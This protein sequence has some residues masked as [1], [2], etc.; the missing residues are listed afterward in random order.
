MFM[1]QIQSQ[2]FIVVMV[3]AA[4][5]LQFEVIS[6]FETEVFP[7]T[8]DHYSSLLFLPHGVKILLAFMFGFVALP[9]IFIGRFLAGILLLDSPVYDALVGTVFGCIAIFT[10]VAFINVAFKK[11]WYAGINF[12]ENYT[13]NTFHIFIILVLLSTFLNVV[14][15]SAYYHVEATIMMPFRYFVGDILG[16]V[17]IFTLLM[18]AR[19]YIFQYFLRKAHD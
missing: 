7:H 10:P 2:L 17:L 8:D 1:R 12:N 18:L 19:K 4:F 9:A 14:L 11:K 6:P 15:H 16:S 3:L 5:Y 13:I